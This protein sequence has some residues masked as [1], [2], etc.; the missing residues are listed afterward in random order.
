M[1]KQSKFFQVICPECK[2]PFHMRFPEENPG[3]EG[4]GDMKITCMYCSK[5]I[6]VTIP[7]PYIPAGAP[8]FK[9]EE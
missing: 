4:T 3:A 1:E 2:K 9:G 7:R 8:T 6:M 5:D